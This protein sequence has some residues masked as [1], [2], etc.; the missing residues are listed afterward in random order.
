MG[1]KSADP[2]SDDQ[3]PPSKRMAM[4]PATDPGFDLNAFR[5]N[6][7]PLEGIDVTAWAAGIAPFL[8]QVIEMSPRDLKV[9]VSDPLP[10]GTIVDLEVTTSLTDST[11]SVRGLV[12]WQVSRPDGWWL[13]IFLNS[14]L[15]RDTVAPYWSDLR[16]ELRY[17]CQ[18]PC[19]IHQT[20]PTSH[21]DGTLLNYSRSG[22]LIESERPARFEERITLSTRGDRSPVIHA[23]VRWHT[24]NDAGRSLIGCEV[25]DEQGLRLARFLQTVD[26]LPQ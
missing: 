8:G 11:A 12:H 1:A 6:G 13:G 17:D 24:R 22:L 7:M 25:D 10:P 5:D 21:H 9:L 23:I 16:K 26:A 18:W 19:A 20:R 14:T 15:P 2:P 4:L 3:L